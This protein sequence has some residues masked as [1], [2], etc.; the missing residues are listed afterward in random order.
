MGSATFLV[1]HV[2]ALPEFALEL[3]DR[4]GKQVLVD[5][6]RRR[7][8]VP[9]VTAINGD[10]IFPDLRHSRA[11]FCPAAGCGVTIVSFNS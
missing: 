6:L 9:A 2:L 8:S 1:G 4:R 10:E 3:L 5:G 11:K 7:P